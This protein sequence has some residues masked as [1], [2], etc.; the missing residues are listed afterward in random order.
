MTLK[1]GECFCTWEDTT[2]D[3]WGLNT[4]CGMAECAMMVATQRFHRE[5]CWAKTDRVTVVLICC[6]GCHMVMVNFFFDKG[7]WKLMAKNS[8]LMGP[9]HVGCVILHFWP[10]AVILFAKQRS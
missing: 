1:V 7:L 2:L 3:G 8:D 9:S 10:K 4:M 5:G 6:L